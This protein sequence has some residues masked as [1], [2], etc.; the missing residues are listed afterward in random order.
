MLISVELRLDGVRCKVR[1]LPY[2]AE[3]VM[4]VDAIPQ[5]YSC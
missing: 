3:M 2:E 5:E 1:V 4:E